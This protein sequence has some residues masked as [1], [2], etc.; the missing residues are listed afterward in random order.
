MKIAELGNSGFEEFFICGICG[1]DIAILE[2]TALC[3][4][5][6]QIGM[7]FSGKKLT[8]RTWEVYAVVTQSASRNTNPGIISA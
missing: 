3:P 1:S 7:S 6:V 4:A 2:R 8:F 5:D